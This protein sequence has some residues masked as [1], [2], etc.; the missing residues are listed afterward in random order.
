[1]RGS[2]E[3]VVRNSRV[4]FKLTVN[5]NLTILRGDS[6]TGKTTLITMVADYEELGRESGVEVRCERPCVTLSGRGWRQ[7]LASVS[8][9]IVFID[10]GNSFT[11][12]DEFAGA[13]R[14]TDNYYVIACREALAQLPYSVDEVYGIRNTGRHAQK[15]RGITRYYSSTYRIYQHGDLIGGDA[16]PDEV[17]VEDSGSGFEFFR[18]LCAR[19]G[20]R[21]VA[22]GG[23]SNV[24]RALL[25]SEAARPLVVADGAAFGPE[26]ERVLMLCRHRGVTLYLPESFEWLLLSSGL[27]RN[28]ELPAILA[29]PGAFIE[30]RDYFSWERFFFATLSAMTRGTRLQYGKG[31]MSGEWLSDGALSA[32]AAVMPATGL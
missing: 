31:S 25:A 18:A 16:A 14:D 17:I 23:R 6:A 32:V 21:C 10:E 2:Y 30:S 29:D 3:V 7:K 20:V 4:Q 24:Y 8:S 22:A 26:M 5:R 19:S 27:V 11:S 13:I 28:D 12:T 9:S 1:M 15:Y